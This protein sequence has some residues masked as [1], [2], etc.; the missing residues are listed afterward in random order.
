[1]QTVKDEAGLNSFAK[2]YLVGEEDAWIK[3]V[4]GFRN[5]GEL[6]RNEVDTCACVAAGRGTADGGV[7]P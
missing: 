5:N 4:R 3:P 6:V 7:P 2:A 1:M